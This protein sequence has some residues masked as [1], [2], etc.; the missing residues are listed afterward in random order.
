M[1]IIAAAFGD[2]LCTPLA[3]HTRET[4]DSIAMLVYNRREHRGR[5]SI[6]IK[7][8]T[9][10]QAEAPFVFEAF[11]LGSTPDSLMEI[12]DGCA[13]K[14]WTRR[15]RVKVDRAHAGLSVVERVMVKRMRKAFLSSGKMLKQT[16]DVARIE[17]AGFLPR[18]D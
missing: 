2:S 16:L 6:A 10:R 1:R 14:R 12:E 8:C 15:Y 13:W 18:Y 3:E 11:V 7:C 4:R 5:P 9:Q 17:C